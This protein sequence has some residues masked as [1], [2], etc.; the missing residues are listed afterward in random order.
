[1]RIVVV[2]E[3]REGK[4]IFEGTQ[5]DANIENQGKKLVRMIDMVSADGITRM[6]G[7]WT[8]AEKQ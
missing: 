8:A 7:R 5:V 1:M 6:D 4:V 3:N 2:T